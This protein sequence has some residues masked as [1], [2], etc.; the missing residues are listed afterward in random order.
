[1][2]IIKI[3][4]VFLILLA[5]TSLVSAQSKSPN[6]SKKINSF[7][8]EI[9]KV[10]L[11][12]DDFSEKKK[13]TLSKTVV[14][15]D[16]AFELEGNFAKKVSNVMEIPST[17]VQFKVFLLNRKDRTT[18]VP[19][20]FLVDGELV[21]GGDLKSLLSVYETDDFDITGIDTPSAFIAFRYLEQI[22]KGKTVQVKVHDKVYDFSPEI[23]KVFKEF[24][25][26]VKAK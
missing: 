22:S 15:S 6:K 9:G 13:I 18:S 26:K 7:E 5:L 14:G 20:N 2:K 11:D 23:L 4:A 21:K 8:T 17:P 16:F 10:S 1:M 12:N 19:M 25:S 24:V 3:S